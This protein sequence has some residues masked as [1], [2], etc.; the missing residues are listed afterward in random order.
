MNV[1]FYCVQGSGAGLRVLSQEKAADFSIYPS[2][3]ESCSSS[4]VSVLAI[5]EGAKVSCCWL[6]TGEK[7]LFFFYGLCVSNQSGSQP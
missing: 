2:K 6:F 7:W 3:L 4:N 1:H 5:F